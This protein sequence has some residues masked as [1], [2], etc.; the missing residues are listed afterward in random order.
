MHTRLATS[1]V[2]PHL[3]PQTTPAL[4]TFFF[5]ECLL[6]NIYEMMQEQPL[7]SSTS[8]WASLLPAV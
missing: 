1:D 4:I 8:V 5:T 3:E 6:L 2:W 7:P